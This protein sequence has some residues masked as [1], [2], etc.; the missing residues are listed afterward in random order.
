MAIDSNFAPL[1]LVPCCHT[2]SIRKGYQPH[3]LY[4]PNNITAKD[5]G[6]Y[7][8][9]QQ[10]QQQQHQ[11]ENGETASLSL[12]A[13]AAATTTTAT[14]AYK[15][16]KFQIIENVIDTVRFITLQNAYGSNNVVLQTL[17]EIFTER[18]RLFLV[19]KKMKMKRSG[20]KTTSTTIN[21]SVSSDSDDRD[22]RL[23]SE[24]SDSSDSSECVAEIPIKNNVNSNPDQSKKTNLKL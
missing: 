19:Q 20:I 16:K 7:I 12:A 11:Q 3:P 14:A 4:A 9:K 17:P 18:N 13:A 21:S 15:N 1:A 10:Q 8:E 2:Y 24:S 5:V 22:R 23:S 6:Y